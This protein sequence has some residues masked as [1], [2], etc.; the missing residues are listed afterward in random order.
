MR[1]NELRN[2]L[3]ITQ[4][5]FAARYNIPLRTVQNWETGKR[6]PPTYIIELL[7]TRIKSDLINRK[8]IKLPK[9]SKIKKNLPKRNDYIGGLAWLRAVQGCLGNSVVFALDE[10]LMCQG[11]FLGRSDEY[12]VWVYGDNSLLEYNGVVVLG[13]EINPQ[14]VIEKNGLLFTTFNRTIIDAFA[15][16]NILDMQGITEALAKYYSDNGNSFDGL[17]ITPEY[18]N[19]FEQLKEDALDYY[20][21]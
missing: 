1:I 6:I 8:T 7:E 11:N 15:N 2:M 9:Y 16:E 12:I 14:N 17:F 20:C 10:A 13:D 3:G 21:Y 18:Q 4:S 19:R 5:E